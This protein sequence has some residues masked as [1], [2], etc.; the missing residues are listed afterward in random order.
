M[1]SPRELEI[2]RSEVQSLLE[3]SEAY[4]ALPPDARAQLTSDMV[5]VGSFL[6]ENM[7][8]RPVALELVESGGKHMQ[9]FTG[10]GLGETVM[11]PDHKITWK[12]RVGLCQPA[13]PGATNYTCSS[14]DWYAER[15]ITTD[16]NEPASLSIALPP[17]PEQGCSR[18]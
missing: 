18:P 10:T 11:V 6:S 7:L 16:P 5:K 13:T 15:E 9:I 1:K 12:M 4:R 14:T 3:S 17:P 2:V 8:K